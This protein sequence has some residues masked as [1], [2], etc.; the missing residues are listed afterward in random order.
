MKN[1]VLVLACLLA[2]TSLAR[3]GGDGHDNAHALQ[4][5]YFAWVNFII[6]I[7]LAVWKLRAPLRLF[8]QNRYDNIRHELDKVAN[9]RAALHE[10]L[11][12]AQARLANADAEAAQ[13]IKDSEAAAQRQ[14]QK[15][16]EAARAQAEQILRSAAQQVASLEREAQAEIVA[17]AA[18]LL[19]QNASNK[20][21]QQ[22]SASHNAAYSATQ[23]AKLGA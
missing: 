4:L 6:F 18:K 19:T 14:A 5:L 17:I 8:L 21:S 16:I 11:Q 15:I 10:Q 7:V 23:L 9:Q 1:I 13:L 3:A 12:L 22:A 2:L 20:L